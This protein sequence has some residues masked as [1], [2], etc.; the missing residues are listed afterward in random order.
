MSLTKVSLVL[1]LFNSGLS[2]QKKSQTAQ[3]AFTYK[4]E[5]SCELWNTIE[6]TL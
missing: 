5:K 6:K 4:T 3:L 1:D 2:S